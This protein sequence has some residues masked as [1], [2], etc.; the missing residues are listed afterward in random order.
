MDA[1]AED[2]VK[3]IPEPNICSPL[4]WMDALAGA[5]VKRKPEQN[6]CS[7]LLQ[8]LIRAGFAAVLLS[9][10]VVGPQGLEPWTFGLKVRCSAS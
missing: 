10:G 9:S 6:N 1:L 7:P 3:R 2:E 8:A 5:A 4:L